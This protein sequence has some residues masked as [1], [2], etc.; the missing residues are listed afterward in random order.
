[1]STKVLYLLLCCSLCSTGIAQRVSNEVWVSTGVKIPI[2][3]SLAMGVDITQRYGTYG[4]E[5]IFPQ[6]S[7]RYKVNK[8]FKP[9]ID[10]RII[11]S[12]DFDAPIVFSHRINGNLQFNWSKDRLSAGLRARYQYSIASFG[13]N[14]DA[15][16]DQAF[17][18]KPSLSYDLPDFPL[19]PTLSMDWFYSLNN[20]SR[21]TNR[22]RH[23]LSFDVDLDG[24]HSVDFGIMLDQ[25]VNDIPRWRFMYNVGYSYAF[26]S[27]QNG[28]AKAKNVRDL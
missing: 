23:S 8:W 16:F 19:T 20:E 21:G 18:F 22:F 14:A 26:K 12:R 13:G 3:K 27:K 11:G 1:M 9:S 5:T 17:R 6:V 24:P 2:N 10:Y 7:V 4:L 15:E 28:D 25:W